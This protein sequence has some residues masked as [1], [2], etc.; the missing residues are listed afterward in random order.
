MNKNHI[1]SRDQYRVVFQNRLKPNTTKENVL[2][3]LSNTFKKDR[4]SFEPLFNKKRSVLKKNMDWESACRYFERFESFGM[5][6]QIEVIL[7]SQSFRNAVVP[8]DQV[9][10]A[11]NST[12]KETGDKSESGIDKKKSQPTLD[13]SEDLW[14]ETSKVNPAVFSPPN[15]AEIH[16]KSGKTVGYIKNSKYV[17]S[18]RLAFFIAT[19]FSFLL[20]VKFAVY[21]ANTFGTGFEGTAISLFILVTGIYLLG[22]SLTTRREFQIYRQGHTN[23]L[24][25]KCNQVS[26]YNLFQRTYKIY[27][28]SGK[29]SYKIKKNLMKHS[30]TCVNENDQIILHAEEEPETDELL[31]DTAKEIRNTILDSNLLDV[32]GAAKGLR[33]RN[34]PKK[35]YIIRNSDRVAV[36]HFVLA[37]FS[38]VKI[39]RNTNGEP[40]RKSIYALMLVLSGM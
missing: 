22:I 33:D 36:G 21:F 31:L 26:R 39:Y 5:I 35:I 15:T 12:N 27:E 24:F 37:K 10:S 8:I 30:V 9:G 14:F 20:Q 1:N 34:K 23:E 13:D 19:L 11:I 7:N 4:N 40:D 2:D 29:N 3:A 32:V 38:M 28:D 25:L 18:I 6:T 16:H 17:L